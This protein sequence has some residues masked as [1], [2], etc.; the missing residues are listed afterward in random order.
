M[1]FTG[2][3][4][5]LTSEGLAAAADRLGVKAPEV[6]AVISVE[7]H[8]TGFIASRQ[9]Q[10]LFE[11]H[12]FAHLTAGR[13]NSTNPDLSA[14]TPGGY[15]SCGPHQYARLQQAV[16]LDRE[17]ALQ[18]ASWGMAQIM[19]SNCKAAGFTDVD[20]MVGAMLDSE[21]AHL[22]A[23]VQFILANHLQPYLQVHDWASFARGY[24]GP[25]YVINRYDV[26]LRG[27]YQKFLVGAFPDLKIRAAQLYLQFRG[28][29]PHGID[30]IAG[31]ST[32]DALKVFQRSLG[33]AP[34]GVLDDALLQALM[35]E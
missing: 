3:S 23:M 18:S 11:R 4:L 7:T 9:P 32:I 13:Y 30:G 22:M 24:N 29:D 5:A 31:P 12:I 19:G 1:E 15:G 8:G 6:W 25:N 2:K 17:A 10:I 34:T 21:D 26:Q 14:S 28:Y 16:A 20:T 35:P 33:Q 27:N